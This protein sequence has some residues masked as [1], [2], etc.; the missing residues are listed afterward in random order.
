LELGNCLGSTA[1][2]GHEHH[3]HKVLRHLC[4]RHTAEHGSSSS[5][6]LCQLLLSHLLRRLVLAA[7][8]FTTSAADTLEV[9]L[10]LLLEAPHA[11]HTQPLLPC[12]LP[13]PALA[14]LKHHAKHAAH[15]VANPSSRRR[16]LLLAEGSA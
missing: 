15:R 4:R 9:V 8:I 5:S 11:R 14:A 1:G 6:K 7:I 13:Q 3:L 2:E 12:S 10:L 16:R